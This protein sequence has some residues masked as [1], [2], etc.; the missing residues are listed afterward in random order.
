MGNE[1]KYR[2]ADVLTLIFLIGSLVVR[3]GTI[4]YYPPYNGYIA[5]FLGCGI[6]GCGFVVIFPKYL[7]VLLFLFG[8]SFFLFGFGSIDI[9]SRIFELI[10]T[11]VGTT[12]FFINKRKKTKNGLNEKLSI[13]ILCYVCL[14][15]FSLLLMPVRQIVRDLWFFGFPDS[16]YYLFISPPYGFYYPVAMVIQLMLFT[17]L[18]IQLSE[19]DDR[20][21]TFNYLFSGILS[22]AVF[23][24]FIGLLD[25]YG[26]VPLA[27]YRFGTTVTPGVLHSTFQ[28]RDVFGEY[29]LTA[30]PFAM[31]GF[32]SKRNGMWWK[33]FLFGCLVICEIA[34]ILSGGR[35]GW[36]AYPLILFFCWSLSYFIKE[37]RFEISHFRWRDFAKIAIS[38]PVTIIISLVLVFY[39]LIPLSDNG[40]SVN[41]TNQI[42]RIRELHSGGRDVTWRQGF[43]VGMESPVYGVGYESFL[44]HANSLIKTPGSHLKKYCG[45]SIP[46]DDSPHNVLISAFVN[47]GIVGLCFWLLI[48]GYAVIIL[49]ADLIKNRSLLNL[50][51]II[52]I[53]SFHL[54][55]M[56][57]SMQVIPMIWLLLN[58]GYALTVDDD[59][60]PARVRHISA[61]LAT[62]CV[63][64]VGVG[65]MV[66]ANHFESRQTNI[67]V[68]SKVLLGL[69]Q[70]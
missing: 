42:D 24:A 40:T 56:A 15:V 57:Q 5:I 51:V 69:D 67:R 12:L 36:V 22:G 26:I 54:F 64:L 63:V 68:L 18:A 16:F 17:V 48:V 41:V 46:L 28:N 65:F 59:V 4:F 14:S 49:T 62:L 1:N 11:C 2:I 3:F 27:W 30:I 44:W 9:Q 61:L 10:V 25:F 70:S 21:I 58:L 53:I 47:G 31:I 34:L 38:V 52:S 8:F 33:T 55:G 13:L 20:N 60:L 6:L 35:T 45:E 50:P 7:K 29:V 19:G 37:G 32:M 39:I 23:C 66:Y 43:Y